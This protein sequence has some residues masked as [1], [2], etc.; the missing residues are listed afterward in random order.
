MSRL[1]DGKGLE[2]IAVTCEEKN[3]QKQFE[4]RI[5]SLASELDCQSEIPRWSPYTACLKPSTSEKQAV[6][7][8]IQSRS[9]LERSPNLDYL[10]AS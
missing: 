2:V 8:A 1:T 9:W 4:A 3:G 5:E 6:L 7:D 10:F